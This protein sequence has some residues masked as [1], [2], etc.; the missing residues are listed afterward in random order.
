VGAVEVESTPTP[1]PE[2]LLML[3][4]AK[5][6]VSH[7]QVL[8]VVHEE[9]T[10]L[11][12]DGTQVT[13]PGEII[14]LVVAVPRA[15]QELLE[16]AIDNGQVRVALLS[17]RLDGDT[18]AGAHRP[19]LGM[20]WNDLVALIRM[21]RERSLASGLP[22]EVIGPGAY[23]VEATRSVATQAAEQT[24]AAFVATPSPSPTVY[25]P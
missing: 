14:G 5:T 25:R 7:A 3:P 23:A 22:A 17:A 2:P 1:T 16:F 6:I 13:T 19:T 9:R 15:A 12:S 8:A 10:T 18:S 20:T 4:V 21:E 24:R 11:A